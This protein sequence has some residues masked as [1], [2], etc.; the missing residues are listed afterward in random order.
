MNIKKDFEEKE[1]FL[2]TKEEDGTYVVYSSE[3]YLITE[4]EVINLIKILVN[5]RRGVSVGRKIM[6]VYKDSTEHRKE[7]TQERLKNIGI[8][9]DEKSTTTCK[10]KDIT[11]K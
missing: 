3:P 9:D 5:E 4:I 2:S 8:K 6:E 11:A 10:Q 7:L 1:F